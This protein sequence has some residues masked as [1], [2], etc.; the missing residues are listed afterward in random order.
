MSVELKPC[1]FCGGK[2]DIKVVSRGHTETAY[3]IGAE[4]GCPKCN[5]YMLGDTI[6]VVDEFVNV[7]MISKGVQH[8]IENWNRRGGRWED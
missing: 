4:V 2:A 7:K 5:F 6:F 1:P 8:M 3:S